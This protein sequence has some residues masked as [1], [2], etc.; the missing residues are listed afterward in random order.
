M[1]L[2][3][4]YYVNEKPVPAAVV[5]FETFNVSGDESNVGSTWDSGWIVRDDRKRMVKLKLRRRIMSWNLLF[6]T[7]VCFR[8]HNW[9]GWV[10][11][12]TDTSINGT[13]TVYVNELNSTY[14]NMTLRYQ[15]EESGR[16]SHDGDTGIYIYRGR[17]STNYAAYFVP[18]LAG[19]ATVYYQAMGNLDFEWSLSAAKSDAV[20]VMPFK[21]PVVNL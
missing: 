2:D 21:T 16:S 17:T 18:R 20:G 8:K 15:H 3:R 4:A 12:R 11:Y 19:K 13:A 6:H 1:D 10:N 14:T 7:E 5:N 9:R